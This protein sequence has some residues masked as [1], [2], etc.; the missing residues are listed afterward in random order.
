VLLADW[1]LSVL[2]VPPHR[3]GDLLHRRGGLLETGRLLLGALQEIGRAGRCIHTLPLNRETPDTEPACTRDKPCLTS[4]DT[5]KAISARKAEAQKNK[6]NVSIAVLDEGGLLLDFHRMDGAPPIS[7]EVSIGKACTA[8]VTKR[9]SK[10]CEDRV[11]E[12]PAFANSR[13]G[14]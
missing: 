6:W 9:S 7:A 13:P 10:F 4:A 11:K 5:A 2:G 8:A 14:F 3:D 12:G 1:L